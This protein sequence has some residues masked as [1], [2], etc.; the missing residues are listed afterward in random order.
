[1]NV[2][3]PNAEYRLFQQFLGASKQKILGIVML[4]LPV[5]PIPAIDPSP[6]NFPEFDPRISIPIFLKW[7][8]LFSR[9]K[10][11]KAICGVLG[12]LERDLWIS[13]EASLSHTAF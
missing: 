11:T 9:Q 10:R 3:G 1:M 4:L 12:Y 2:F 7:I 6:G 5:C 13:A 8:F